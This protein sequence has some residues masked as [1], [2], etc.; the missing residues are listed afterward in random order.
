[1]KFMFIVKNVYRN[2]K[3]E[4][5]GVGRGWGSEEK[6]ISQYNIS[7][8]K[9]IP[10]R[11]CVLFVCNRKMDFCTVICTRIY[12]ILYIYI[13]INLCTSRHVPFIGSQRIAFIWRINI[14]TSLSQIRYIISAVYNIM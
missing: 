9:R 5:N 6:T 4:R 7:I 10:S 8:G 14:Y 2:R 13:N 1:M 12:N 3:S 11:K